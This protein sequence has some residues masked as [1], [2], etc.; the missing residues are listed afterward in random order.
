M[1]DRP[2]NGFV[3]TA[4]DEGVGATEALPPPSPPSGRVRFHGLITVSVML[5][6]IMQAL[7]TTIANVALPKMQGTLSATQDEM[8]WV[9]TSYIVAAAITIPLT[10]WLAGEL[11]RRKVFLV[12][13]FVFTV[14]SAL[15]GVAT[16][17]DQIVLFRFL[18]GVGGAALVPLSQAVLFDI[19]P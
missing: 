7:D 13:I 6:T 8:G 17:L 18:Q 14:A 2:E 11:G 1:P 5:A 19:N 4:R 16:S 12:S 10:G 15:C 9:L 3:E